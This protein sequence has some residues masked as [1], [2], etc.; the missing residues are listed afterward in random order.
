MAE[1]CESQ[2]LS[3]LS[4]PPTSPGRCLGISPALAETMTGRKVFK[5]PHASQRRAEPPPEG[6]EPLPL[7]RNGAFCGLRARDFVQTD[8]ACLDEVPGRLNGRVRRKFI[9]AFQPAAKVLR[10]RRAPSL[11]I[12]SEGASLPE[13]CRGL[14]F[15]ARS[16]RNRA[17]PKATRP[18]SRHGHPTEWPTPS[19][20]VGQVRPCLRQVRTRLTTVRK[21]TYKF[22]AHPNGLSQ[23]S[24]MSQDQQAAW[25]RIV[26]LRAHAQLGKGVC[27]KCRWASS[28]SVAEEDGFL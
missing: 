4:C 22:S 24:V 10:T 8:T 1:N 27:R 25:H 6:A 2:Y 20:G 28:T 14:E 15:R 26:L 9:G 11:G 5:R 21:V 19:E 23:N 12:T 17:E 18:D 13:D 3:R 7:S 16:A